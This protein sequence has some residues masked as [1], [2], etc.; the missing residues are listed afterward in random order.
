MLQAIDDP[1]AQLVVLEYIRREFPAGAAIG[2][3][4][5]LLRGV[6]DSLGVFSVVE[7]LETRF[8]VVFDDDDLTVANFKS[9]N[10]M[11]ALLKARAAK[12]P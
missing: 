10:A 2:P 5:D 3:E 8:G 6:I 1:Q 11:L 9:V 7:F 4:D 12:A